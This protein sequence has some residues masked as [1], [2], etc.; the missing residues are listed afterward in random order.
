MTYRVIFSSD[1]MAL[2]VLRQNSVTASSLF[3]RGAANG[4]VC[5]TCHSYS[6][7]PIKPT[8]EWKMNRKTLLVQPVSGPSNSV[9]GRQELCRRAGVQFDGALDYF[10]QGANLQ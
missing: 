2:D 5:K 6:F 7:R 4:R 3:D 10:N 1:K 8:E 9:D